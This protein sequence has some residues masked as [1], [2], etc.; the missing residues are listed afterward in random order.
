MS[1]MLYFTEYCNFAGAS[2][3]EGLCG[4]QRCKETAE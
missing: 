2:G 1:Q 4:A 3:F